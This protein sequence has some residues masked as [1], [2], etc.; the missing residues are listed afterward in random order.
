M[1]LSLLCEWY[2]VTDNTQRQMVTGLLF[3]KFLSSD[4]NKYVTIWTCD[5]EVV[6]NSNDDIVNAIAL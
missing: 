6:Y 4:N 5:C 3:I 2:L 1:D